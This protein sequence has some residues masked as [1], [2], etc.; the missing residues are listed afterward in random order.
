MYNDRLLDKQLFLIYKNIE[1][2][3][4]QFIKKI[5]FNFIQAKNLRS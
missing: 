1:I 4:K 2:P 5:N 3:K